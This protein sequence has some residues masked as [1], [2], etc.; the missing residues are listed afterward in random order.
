MHI[1]TLCWHRASK[2]WSALLTQY[3]SRIGFKCGM[4][5]R[6]G[7]A[8]WAAFVR[9]V[10]AEHKAKFVRALTPAS[11]VLCCNGKLD[12]TP[13]PQHVQINLMRVTSTQCGQQ[14]PMLHMDHTHDVNLI[15]DVWSRALPKKPGSWDDGICGPLIA[16]LLFGTE[17]HLLTQCSPR[18]IWRQQLV[19]RCGNVNGVAGQH[20]EDFCHDVAKAHFG[21]TLQVSDIKWPEVPKPIDLNEGPENP[22]NKLDL[23]EEDDSETEWDSDEPPP[24]PLV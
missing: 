13:C 17:D 10:T 4:R 3:K 11:G 22:E 18:P 15:C 14:L 7:E 19:V 9:H 21:H 2:R 8:H 6:L 12:G 20:A 1:K 5:K 23:N 16:H 24:L